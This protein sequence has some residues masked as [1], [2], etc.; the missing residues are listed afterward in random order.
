MPEV[1]FQQPLTKALSIADAQPAHGL[2][3]RFHS[4]RQSKEDGRLHG[5]AAEAGSDLAGLPFVLGDACRMK[6][7]ARQRF[8]GARKDLQDAIQKA[9]NPTQL[10]IFPP[11]VEGAGERHR[12]MPLPPKD[13]LEVYEEVESANANKTDAPARVATLMQMCSNRPTRRRRIHG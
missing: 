9:D 5:G 1:Y 11:V 7:E 10:L 6:D 13:R 4:F 8:V 12:Y 3:H 2:H